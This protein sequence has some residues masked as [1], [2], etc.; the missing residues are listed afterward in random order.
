MEIP[1]KIGPLPTWSFAIVLLGGLA[2]SYYLYSRQGSSSDEPILVE[3]TSPAPGVGQYA[4]GWAYTPPAAA[5]PEDKTFE[6][7]QE[8][9]RYVIS[10]MIAEGYDPGAVDSMVR[11]YLQGRGLTAQEAELRDIALAKYG[12]PPYINVPA[13]PDEEIPTDDDEEEPTTPPP[14]PSNGKLPAPT[15]LVAQQVSQGKIHIQWNAVPGANG[16]YWVRAT[17]PMS[18]TGLAIRFGTQFW[19]DGLKPGTYKIEVAAR[20]NLLSLDFGNVATITTTVA[21]QGAA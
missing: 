4:M 10:H 12:P 20:K 19:H 6:T 3:D 8:W 15:G 2:V 16:G 13:E 1:K 5:T 14:A 17:G 21:A 18:K 11:K 9:A 7:N